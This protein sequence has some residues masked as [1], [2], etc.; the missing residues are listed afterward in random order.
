MTGEPTVVQSADQPSGHAEFVDAGIA[1]NRPD[2]PVGPYEPSTADE[3][4]ALI[5]LADH[6]HQRF[7]VHGRGDIVP[8][9]KVTPLGAYGFAGVIRS[10]AHEATVACTR[11]G[12]PS[13]S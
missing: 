4:G 8:A 3:I 5:V 13:M 2:L 7:P 1:G 9:R 12:G 6:Q 11:R 10:E